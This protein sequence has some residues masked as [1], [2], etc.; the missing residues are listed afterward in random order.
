MPKRR[1]VLLDIPPKSFARVKKEL[2]KINAETLKKRKSRGQISVPGVVAALI[3][4][5]IALLLVPIIQTLSEP[6]LASDAAALTKIIV[7]L[8]PTIYILMPLLGYIF[9]ASAT[10]TPRV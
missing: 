8:I 7:Q 3:A 6:V 10:R 2:A 4:F 1:I 5:V 9:L